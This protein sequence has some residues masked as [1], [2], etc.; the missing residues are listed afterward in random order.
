MRTLLWADAFCALQLFLHRSESFNPSY[1]VLM[2]A[3]FFQL[4][5]LSIKQLSNGS[6]YGQLVDQRWSES[7]F[8]MT[9]EQLQWGMI[10]SLMAVTHGG[11][12]TLSH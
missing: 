9:H 1:F 7:P 8:V 5:Q 10:G 3:Q 12:T 11:L 6:Q 4:K 2:H